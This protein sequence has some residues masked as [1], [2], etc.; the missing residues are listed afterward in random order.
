MPE[1]GLTNSEDHFGLLRSDYSEKPAFVAIKNLLSI[2][3]YVA[4]ATPTPLPYSLS[5]DTAGDLQQLVLQRAN[6][7]YLVALWR[8][9]SIWD[10]TALTDISVTPEQISVGLPTATSVTTADPITST[11]AAGLPLSQGRVSVPIG[12]DPV[13]L[14]V[15]T[16]QP[17]LS[18]GTGIVGPAASSGSRGSKPGKPTASHAGLSGVVRRNAKLSFTLASGKNAAALKTI[19]LALSKGLGFSTS[20]KNLV[21]GIAVKTG[22]KRLK[23]TAKVSHGKL[24]ITLKTPASRVQV[25]IASP[26]ITVSKTLAGNAKHHKIR[27][28]QVLMTATDTSHTTTRITLKPGAK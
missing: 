8:T 4:P 12:A 21:N 11:T 9:A 2:V 19:T 24:T 25:T 27:T 20:R 10:H 18:A 7:S 15:T 3:G 6:G 14:T 16:N 1:P 28:L 23:F 26:A 22:G 5:G 13:I 17:R